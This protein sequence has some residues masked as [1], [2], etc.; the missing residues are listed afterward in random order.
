MTLLQKTRLSFKYAAFIYLISVVYS[1]AAAGLCG[2][3]P[4]MTPTCVILK[5]FSIPI[6]LYLFI[7]TRSKHGIYFYINLGISKIEYYAIPVLAEFIFFVLL[8]T[9]SITLGNVVR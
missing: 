2:F 7:S 1:L 9:L 4:T 6:V 5:I 8:L 3:F